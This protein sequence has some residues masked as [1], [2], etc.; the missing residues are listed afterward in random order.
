[1]Q[2]KLIV[3]SSSLW[4]NPDDQFVLR[5]N[6]INEERQKKFAERIKVTAGQRR[7]QN[8]NGPSNEE[9][10]N[11]L[12][13]INP[14]LYSEG[15][16][17]NVFSHLSYR[18][19]NNQNVHTLSGYYHRK[20]NQILYRILCLKKPNRGDIKTAMELSVINLNRNENPP[21]RSQI[22]EILQNQFDPTRNNTQTDLSP[23]EEI[24]IEDIREARE[25]AENRTSYLRE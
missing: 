6:D 9:I 11:L 16:R 5:L 18:H 23:P 25:T 21:Y 8:I 15:T 22:E 12:K 24:G 3:D 17:R 10:L 20:L 1:M 7:L 14:I 4:K 13:E 19:W 2:K